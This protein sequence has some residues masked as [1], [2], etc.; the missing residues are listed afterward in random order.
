L[1]TL[2]D[3]KHLSTK[4]FKAKDG[5]ARRRS[6]GLKESDYSKFSMSDVV[7]ISNFKGGFAGEQLSRLLNAKQ[8]RSRER[9]DMSRTMGSTSKIP[10]TFN[11][12]SARTVYR[13]KPAI[14]D[15]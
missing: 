1:Q 9:E 11:I 12:N 15:P 14:V 6:V 3:G 4:V 13:D 10:S 5:V 7:R 8:S 2:P